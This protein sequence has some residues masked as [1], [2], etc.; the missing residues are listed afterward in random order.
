MKKAVLLLAMVFMFHFWACSQEQK[1]KQWFS[2]DA[3]NNKL[4][5]ISGNETSLKSV[6][7]MN[8]GKVV[9]ID[10][11]AT[12]CKDCIAGIPKVKKLHEKYEKDLVEF[13]FLSVDKQTDKWKKG[14]KK[15]NLPGQHYFIDGGWK[16]KLCASLPLDWIPRYMII[17]KTGKIS[18]Y[19]VV[20]AKDKKLTETIDKL[21]KKKL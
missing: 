5:K 3:L 17:D 18:V 2:D 1:A 21:L 20:D 14:I 12:W 19:R 13:V 9:L 11:W 4:I 15:Y 16:S 7:E 10:I 6:L 8:K